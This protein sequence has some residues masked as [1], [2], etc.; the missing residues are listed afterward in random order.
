LRSW[1]NQQE[2]PVR[3]QLRLP[4]FRQKEP[5]GGEVET[6]RG[7]KGKKAGWHWT[8]GLKDTIF[9]GIGVVGLMMMS[10]ALGAL[11][12]RGDIYRAAY[13]W[14]LMNPDGAKVAQWT[15][16]PGPPALAPVVAPGTA[17]SPTATAA[18]APAPAAAPAP[19]APV[20]PAA[21]P[22][23]PG[24][25]TGSIAA[26]P[27]PAAAKKKG[28]TGTTQRDPKA[29]EEEMRQ[30]RQEVVPKLKFQNSFDTGL[31]PR[32][33]KSKDHDKAQATPV[34]VGQYRSNKEAQ[35]KVAELQKKGVKATL[36]QTKDA[37]GPL[38]TVYKPGSPAQPGAEKLVQ[39]PEKSS[40]PAPKPKSE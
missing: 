1:T 13:S 17:T 22:E 20:T 30:V 6:G 5:I 27:P 31:K 21:K 7:K 35:A 25:V 8:L 33:T 12:G 14:G 34:K 29:R 36:K 15:P 39:K 28:S 19:P 23:Q 16:P 3:Q 40:N 10:F 11:A 26:L 24:P 38:Y 37:K 18:V 4:G 9:A 32:L 2:N